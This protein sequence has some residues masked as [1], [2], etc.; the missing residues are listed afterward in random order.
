MNILMNIPVT[1]RENALADALVS[2]TVNTPVSAA[3]NTSVSTPVSTCRCPPLPK[4]L[5]ITRRV[6]L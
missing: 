1:T 5:L 3:V 2:I 4:N 6:V